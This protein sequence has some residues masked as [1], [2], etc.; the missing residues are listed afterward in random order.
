MF[1]LNLVQLDQRVV[2][3]EIGNGLDGGLRVGNLLLLLLDLV[4]QLDHL[5]LQDVLL[6]LH[7]L[8][9][10]LEKFHLPFFLL[11]TDLQVHDFLGVGEYYLFIVRFYLFELGFK[12]YDPCL[13]LF[14]NILLNSEQILQIINILLQRYGH[15]LIL[16][17]LSLEK[18]LHILE[19]VQ[20]GLQVPLMLVLLDLL[21]VS[22]AGSHLV[23]GDIACTEGVHGDVD[24]GPFAGGHD[25]LDEEG[26]FDEAV[27]VDADA[28]QFEYLV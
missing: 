12:F 4:H 1:L 13:V 9:L 24:L 27:K 28:G 14:V 18:L 3:K 20:L 5:L 25:V 15:L 7:L 11:Q 2:V 26:R 21:L 8:V 19:H 6:G 10:G 23:V 17:Q 16:H 22:H